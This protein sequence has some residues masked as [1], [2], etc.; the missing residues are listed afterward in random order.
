MQMDSKAGAKLRDKLT[1]RSGADG[2]LQEGCLA[3]VSRG[4]RRPVRV[5][6][7]PDMCGP[8]NEVKGQCGTTRAP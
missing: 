6:L 4:I 1:A 7:D 5:R 8:T 3:H 2:I